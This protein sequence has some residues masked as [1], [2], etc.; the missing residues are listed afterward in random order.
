M[1]VWSKL[2]NFPAKFCFRK[3]LGEQTAMEKDHLN[4]QTKAFSK[5]NSY[6]LRNSL[7]SLKVHVPHNY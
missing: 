7:F 3:Q 5:S 6:F 1:Q 2:A 4:V